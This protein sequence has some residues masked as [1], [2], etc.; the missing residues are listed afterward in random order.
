MTGESWT[1]LGRV[2]HCA[3]PV[4]LG[5]V[6]SAGSQPD[7]HIRRHA[8]AFG[9]S[10]VIFWT[11]TSS[12]VGEQFVGFRAVPTCSACGQYCLAHQCHSCACLSRCRSGHGPLLS[13][14]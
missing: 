8:A 4:M 3:Q 11:W 10:A 1:V 14:H 13:I 6:T 5:G 9:D 7:L 12:K 2:R